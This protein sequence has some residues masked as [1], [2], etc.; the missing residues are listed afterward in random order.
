[1]SFAGAVAVTFV[2]GIAII[3]DSAQ[4]SACVTVLAPLGYVGTA[5]TTQTALGF[6]LTMLTIRLVPG[7]AATW[8]WQAAYAPLAI[9]PALGILAMWRLWVVRRI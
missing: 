2:W 7:W 5:V 6:L 4:F 8:G 3:A 1:M 9:G